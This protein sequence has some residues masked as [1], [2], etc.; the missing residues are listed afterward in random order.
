MR[1][2]TTP[3]PIRP[4]ADGPPPVPTGHHTPPPLSDGYSRTADSPP[5]T[6]GGG[7][8]WRQRLPL[9]AAAAGTVLVVAGLAALLVTA[10][11]GLAPQ[12][13]GGVLALTAALLSAAA[14]NVDVAA[15]SRWHTPAAT[16]VFASA[17]A[18][19]VAAV[20]LTVGGWLPGRVAI[21]LAGIAGAAHAGWV[22]SRQPASPGRMAVCTAA[23]LAAAGPAGTSIDDRWADMTSASIP[24]A[25][26]PLVGLFDLVVSTEVFLL[27]AVGWVAAAAM[28]LAVSA[29]L[30][31]RARSTTTATATAVMLWAA[32]MVNVSSAPLA[33][34]AALLLVGTYTVYGLLARRNGVA[35]TGGVA[36][37]FVAVRV[38]A[39]LF[40]GQ[41][42]TIVATI[43]CGVAL[44]SWALWALRRQRAGDAAAG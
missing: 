33:S 34:L 4:H 35:W 15:R 27:P 19:T 37:A 14:V 10:W 30:D 9:A 11:D 26:W 24:P 40:G 41:L 12:V 20:T 8:G 7:V 1:L 32:L 21:G 18:L 38:A 39:G 23:L 16:L 5:A 25:G 13:Q 2:P 29:R 31:G 42:T 36:T 22:W 43:V 28:L 44:L 6:V 17:T 3:P